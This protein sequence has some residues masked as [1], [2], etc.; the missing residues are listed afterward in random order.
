MPAIQLTEA[1]MRNI[2][3]KRAALVW[4]APLFVLAA[5]LF[6]D[7]DGGVN[8][9]VWLMM[10][11]KAFVL[12]AMAHL[13]RKAL[14]DY[15]E[16]D[17]QR[18]FR[19][20]GRSATGAGLALI[21][22]AIIISAILGLFA[23]QAKAQDVRTYI[24]L[25]AIQYAPV[26][27]QEQ[28]AHWPDHPAP[29]VLGALVEHESCISLTHSRCWNPKSSLRTSREEGA[30][31]GQITRAYRADGS[32]RFDALQDMVERHPAL[33]GWS[34][35]NV[36]ARPDMQLRAV[37]LMTRDGYTALRM[38]RDPMERLAFTDAAYNG[39]LGGV[40][41]ERRACGLK[42]GCDPQRWWGHVEGVCLKSKAALYGR[43]S[44]CDINRHHVHDVLQ[45]RAPKYRVL[46]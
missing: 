14:H 19:E 17:M 34:W 25:G 5:L 37:V 32:V 2:F 8:V 4:L 15:P 7:P 13:V 27:K 45:V 31:L 42:D 28:R 21:A 29:H 35:S 30:G 18:L 44:A 43:R 39:G 23:G 3:R 6:T 24:P 36:Y 41:A 1:G 46:L 22:L 20:A 26:L 40:Q 38:V 10:A 11:A 9:G 16:A 33:A 12:V